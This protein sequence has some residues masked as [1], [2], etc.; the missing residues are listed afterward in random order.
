MADPPLAD[1]LEEARRIAAA[2]REAGVA[3]RIAGGV[4]VAAPLSKRHA[5]AAAAHLCGR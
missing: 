1:L 4:A 3:L 2:A 5:G